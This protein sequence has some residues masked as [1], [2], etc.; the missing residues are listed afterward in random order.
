MLYRGEIPLLL[1]DLLI[2]SQH[3]LIKQSYQSRERTEPLNGDGFGIGWYDP[4]FS[5]HPCIY[6]GIRPAWA[7]SNLRR[8]SHFVRS[9]CLFAHVRAATVGFPV[10]E[11]NCHP[12]RYRHLMWMH[13]GHI[14]EFRKIKRKLQESLRDECF[15]MMKGSTDSEHL[16][17][18]VLNH[19][20]LSQDEFSAQE[21]QGAVHSALAQVAQWTAEAGIEG[22]CV[23][24]TALTDG[25]SIVATRQATGKT[26][27]AESLYYAIGKSYEPRRRGDQLIP[28]QG[29]PEALLIASEPL[30]ESAWEWI[31]VPVGHSLTMSKNFQLEFHA[32]SS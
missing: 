4:E 8:L 23:Y 11:L 29:R 10:S 21:L 27:K 7:D 19:L 24:N 2:R 6:K 28:P 26:P 16:F 17:A 13:N 12:F 30:T 31:E 15:H 22:T 9:R 1:S 18:L 32:L 3:S 20:D 5:R 25:R 14:E